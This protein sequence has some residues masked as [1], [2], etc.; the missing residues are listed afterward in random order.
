MNGGG[1]PIIS[2]LEAYARSS[3]ARFH[4]PG[5]KGVDGGGM[6]FE[7][8]A[9][10]DITELG[11]SDDLHRPK[12]AIAASRTRLGGRV[13]RARLLFPGKRFYGGRA[14][15]APVAGNGQAGADR[16]RLP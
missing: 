16:A 6:A 13:R 1:E 9:P 7:R 2:M 8:I 4:M 10:I 15:N 3:T 5:H 12:G 14:R 11:F